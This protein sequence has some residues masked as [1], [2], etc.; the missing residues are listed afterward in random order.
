MGFK[1]ACLLKGAISEQWKNNYK[2]EA[3]NFK[4]QKP[5][6]FSSGQLLLCNALENAQEAGSLKSDSEC[7][8]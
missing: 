6:H 8:V 1:N 7:E 5:S 3:C 4:P 2:F